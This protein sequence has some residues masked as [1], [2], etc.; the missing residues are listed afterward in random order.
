MEGW[1]RGRRLWLRAATLIG[2]LLL[3]APRAPAEDWFDAYARGLE[4]LK[5]HK[6]ARA[7]ELFE[8]AIRMRAEPGTNLLTYGT[9]RLDEYY[10]FLRLA[11]A[12]LLLGNVENRFGVASCEGRGPHCR[13]LTRVSDCSII[14]LSPLAS[15]FSRTTCRA[16]STTISAARRRN[17]SSA[18]RR[19]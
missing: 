1:H 5:Q 10:P 14:C 6:G 11:E 18:W 7:V 12:H 4:A 17:A 2:L 8:R 9:N 15:R 19:S 16:A 3:A 13:S